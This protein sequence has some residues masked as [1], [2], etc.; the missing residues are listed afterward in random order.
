V[1]MPV[2][3]SGAAQEVKPSMSTQ[4]VD[5]PYVHIYYMIFPLSGILYIYIYYSHV[6]LCLLVY[7]GLLYD[8]YIIPFIS[9]FEQCSM[10]Y[11]LVK[12]GIPLHG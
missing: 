4:M 10:L 2:P 6:S 12:N 11:W 8:H 3:F 1:V 7:H 5:I 9:A